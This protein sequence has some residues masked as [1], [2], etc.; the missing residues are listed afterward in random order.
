M[1]G[2]QG[3]RISP[4]QA[5]VYPHINGAAEHPFSCHLQW[6]LSQSLDVAALD[7]C[8]Q[9][10]VAGSEIL[11]TRLMPVPGLRH[12]VQ[13][14]D[15]AGSLAVNLQ[16][17]RQHSRVDQDAALARLATQPR[18]WATPLC[19]TLVRLSDEQAVLDLAAASSHFDLASLKWLAGALLQDNPTDLSDTLQYADYAEWRWS[20]V[21]DAPDHPGVSFWKPSGET[22]Q[23]TLQ[24]PLEVALD[25]GFAPT[26]LDLTLPSDLARHSALTPDLLLAAWAAV[27]G[28]LAGQQQ[29]PL[30]LIHESRGAELENTLGLFEQC[31]PVSI[32]LDAQATLLEQSTQVAAT[33]ERAVGWQDYYTGHL[34]AGYAFAWRS[35]DARER[36]AGAVMNP[37]KACLNVRQLPASLH[38]QLV[39]DRHALSAEAAGCLAEQWLQL[40]QGALAEPQ[41]AWA[42][43]PL[44]GTLQS[45]LIGTGASV[46][47]IEPVTL[48]ELIARQVRQQPDAIALSDQNG[49]LSYSHLDA[50]ATQLAHRLVAAGIGPGVPVG[51]LFA[52]SNAA[53]VAMLAVLKAGGAY[54]P[55]DPTYP[56]DRRAYMLADSAIAHI[57]VSSELADSVPATL[58]RFVLDDLAAPDLGDWPALPLPD[59]IDLAYLIYTSGSTGAPKAVEISHGA[60]SFSTQVRMAAYET[61]VRAY[62]LLSSFAFDSSVAGIFWTLAQGGRLVLPA[63]GE[64]LEMSR[65]AQLIAQHQVSHGLSLPSLYQALLDQLQRS[66][67]TDSLA[68]WIVAGEACPPSLIAQHSKTLPHARLVNEYGPT[69]ATVWATYEVLEPNRNVSIGR[70]IA[71]MDLRLLNEF[72]TACGI[73]E[74]GE[75]VLAGPTLARG[76]RHKPEET[77]KAFVTLADGT[78]AYRTGDLACWLADGRL[79]FLGRKDHQVKVRGYRIELGEIERQLCSHS[80]VREAAVIVQ[81][82]AAGKCLLAYILAAHG[83]APDSEA[84]KRFLGERLPSYMVPALVL[85]LASFPRTPNGKLDTRQL[86][87]P[88]SFDESAHV[89]PRNAMETALQAIVAKVLKLSTVSVTDNFFAIGGDSILSLQVV[90]QAHEQGIALS[91]KQVFE[92]QTIAAM[93]EVAQ[94]LA[95]SAAEPQA[96]STEFSASG[97]S[98]DEMQA[99]MAELDEADL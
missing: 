1:S 62:L 13:V 19:V 9:A 18:D 33:L 36:H 41:R 97:L 66:T 17:L 12:P 43:L 96:D 71:G 81:E 22:E 77:A 53:I 14:I 26:R 49:D 38:A 28:R 79:A 82:H 42:Q 85:T 56:A 94:P 67:G 29:V 31:L 88:D 61:P 40:L 59:A 89:A 91:A 86:P 32:E 58:Q 99:L 60:L 84:I 16:D 24:L 25:G 4:Q 37:L 68:C 70:P 80:D 23:A 83:Y 90:A 47:A 63:P 2:L 51:I 30:T 15:E 6:S 64:E 20:L 92:R 73:G 5:S 95:P 35:G 54:V 55:I 21:E 78:R 76:Y 98:D 50:C 10:L 65:L 7:N 45:Q 87:A 11:R 3:F 34:N 57:V 8:L 93:A 74:P 39:Y 44:G 46:P 27:L 52:R 69:E 75:I 72:D 48:V